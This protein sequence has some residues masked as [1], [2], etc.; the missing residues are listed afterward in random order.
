MGLYDREM[1]S[2]DEV[3]SVEN[4][5]PE[6]V[7]RVTSAFLIL[8][9]E[10][11]TG[12]LEPL[13]NEYGGPG[14][15]VRTATEGLRSVVSAA[16][17]PFQL[18]VSAVQQRRFDRF[19]SAERIRSLKS[20]MPGDEPSEEVEKRSAKIA[21]SRMN[22]FM[23]SA[24]G[25]DFIRD[26]VVE[27]LMRS[28]E[29]PII[30][31][32]AQELLT[33]ALVSTW[34]IFEHFTSGFIIDWVNAYPHL[35]KCV[36]SVPELKTYFGKQA[37]DLDAI[38]EH[39]YDLTRSM[40][41]IIFR[42]KRLDNLAVVRAVLSAMFDGQKIREALGERLWILNQKRHLIV[43]KR[44]LVDR[45]YIEKTGD[46]VEIGQRLHLTSHD[47]EDYIISVQQAIISIVNVSNNGSS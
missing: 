5:A 44:G 29:S 3:R 46:D 10:T 38:D 8:G 33:Q 13:A 24:A 12:P 47:L 43:H 16:T 7:N 20:L 23:A 11:V 34:S 37:V 36:L 14:E 15:Y 17:L 22:E 42:G 25:A 19:L 9:I 26:A 1:A 30:N 45:E 4:H 21:N 2:E 27:E 40:G 35:A 39:G 18:A 31:G 6:R 32:A 28:L 41:N